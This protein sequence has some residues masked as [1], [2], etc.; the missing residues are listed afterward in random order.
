MA[1]LGSAHV[2]A[3][4]EGD[5]HDQVRNAIGG[6]AVDAAADVVGGPIFRDLLALL[7]L[8]GRYVTAG[9]IGGPVVPFDL[10]TLY[11]KK[12]T[13]YG[14]SIGYANQF[15]SLLGHIR[16]GRVKPLLAA[17]FPLARFREAQELFVSKNFFGNIVVTP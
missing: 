6:R 3:R 17:T 2:I 10:R 4:D 7:R 1:A 11:L 8:G 14:V 5:V 15:E 13:L 9:A 12:L 16:A